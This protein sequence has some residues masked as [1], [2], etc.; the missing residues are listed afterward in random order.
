MVHAEDTANKAS[1][2]LLETTLKVLNDLER[3]GVMSRYAIGGAMGAT[4]YIEP[5]LTFDL[6]IFVILP[7][8]QSGLLTLTPIYDALRTRG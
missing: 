5:L 7:Q 3:E 1:E 8:S 2:V 4:F 6:D